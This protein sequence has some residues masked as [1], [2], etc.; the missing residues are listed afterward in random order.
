VLLW[1]A[2]TGVSAALLNRGSVR[3]ILKAEE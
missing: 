2:G 1:L 3:N